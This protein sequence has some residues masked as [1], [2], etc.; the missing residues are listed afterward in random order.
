MFAY[1]LLNEGCIAQVYCYT[2]IDM[3]GQTSG[4]PIRFLPDII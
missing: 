1:T 3:I 4:D 2:F